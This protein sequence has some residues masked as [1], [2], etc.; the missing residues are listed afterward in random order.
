MNKALTFLTII[1]TV[2]ACTMNSPN[3]RPAQTYKYT[4]ESVV[5]L[6]VPLSLM[7]REIQAIADSSPMIKKI[8][9]LNMDP[10]TRVLTVDMTVKY[11]LETLLTGWGVEPPKYY[12]DTQNVVIA[13]SF[14]KAKMMANTRYLNLKFHRFDINGTD[15]LSFF[16]T[17]ANVVNTFIVNSDLLNY[18]YDM[19][20]S[21]LPKGDDGEYYRNLMR[22]V[23]ENNGIRVNA[24]M[25]S[26]AF[27]LNLKYIENLANFTRYKEYADLRIW[28]FS[29]FLL[30]G[31]SDVFFHLE[32]GLGKP[33]KVWLSEYDARV[34]EDKSTI[35]EV[36]SAQ[37]KE[38]SNVQQVNSSLK[39]YLA[40]LLDQEKIRKTKLTR[41][42]Q[43][44]IEKFE[45]SFLSRAKENLTLSNENFE[46]DPE[47]EYMHFIGTQKDRIKNYVTDL[48]RRL[49]IDQ[50]IK[51]GGVAGNKKP[52]I[53]KRLG[54]DVVNASMNFLRDY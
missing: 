19:T 17:V 40:K 33:S 14:P 24:T 36:R 20:E 1:A 21:S 18:V 42:Y 15:Y 45:N 11:P 49:T 3:R 30:K 25:K 44:D 53:T 54:S 35:L 2:F 34:A 52:L 7:K 5:K 50:H 6:K 23:L 8:N 47:N 48:D 31:T 4:D 12:T 29:P 51:M 28:Q 41:L 43:N 32:A 39:E 38:F 10:L 27:K 46:A 16:P 37:Y 22:E 26:M 13:V 9:Y